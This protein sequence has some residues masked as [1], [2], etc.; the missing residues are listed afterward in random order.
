MEAKNV[1]RR[2][3]STQSANDICERSP[4][5]EVSETVKK[6]E[7]FADFLPGR[8]VPVAAKARR[9]TRVVSVDH[10][11]NRQ[12]GRSIERDRN[13]RSIK[14]CL[15]CSKGLLHATFIAPRTHSE[16]H[17]KAKRLVESWGRHTKIFNT[18]RLLSSCPITAFNDTSNIPVNDSNAIKKTASCYLSKFQIDYMIDSFAK[19]L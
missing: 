16:R 9:T 8:I 2:S 14:A 13:V 7:M 18:F 5:W 10:L 11:Q 6:P 17:S 19:C 3:N 12:A 15:A 1:E 4:L